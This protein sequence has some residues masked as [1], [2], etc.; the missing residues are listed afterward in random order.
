MS[1]SP[2]FF[3]QLA[4]QGDGLYARVLSRDDLHLRPERLSRAAARRLRAGIAALESWIRRVLLLMALTLEP[5][6]APSGRPWVKIHRPRRATHL[7]LS[8]SP[9]RIFPADTP[10]N[11]DLFSALRRGGGF[12]RRPVWAAPL[13]A[14]LAA[15]KAIIDAP[16]ARARRLAFHI[17]RKR[18]GLLIPP[19]YR[20]PSSGRLF[21]T[22]AGALHDGLGQAIMEQTRARPPPLG[23]AP[24]AGP[25]IRAL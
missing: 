18:P 7:P 23:P 12:D 8:R 13:L 20:G 24:R 1:L 3:S 21:G 9:L 10:F 17:A 6:L 19:P 11:P 22:E 14:R 25:R 4:I 16:E 15:L 5:D 2:V